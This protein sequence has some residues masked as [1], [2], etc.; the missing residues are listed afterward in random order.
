MTK[1]T[2]CADYEEASVK[3]PVSLTPRQ[4]QILA[5]MQQGKVNKEIARELDISLGT[6]KQHLVAIFKKLNVQ[7]RTMAVAR[8]AEFKDQSGFSEVFARE[9]LMAM[10]PAIVLSLQVNGRLPRAAYKVFHQTLS[11]LAFDA[12]ALFISRQPGEGD[13]I[14]GL[15]RSS[16]QDIR[17]AVQVAGRVYQTM[18]QLAEQEYHLEQTENILTGALVAGLITVSQDRFGGWS[19][20]TIGSHI[21]SWGHDLRKSTAEGELFFDEPV[22]AVMRAFDLTMSGGVPKQI[23]F[24]QTSALCDWNV[25]DDLPLVGRSHEMQAIHSLLQNQFRTLLL[26]GENGMGKSRLC[27]EAAREAVQ[28]GRVLYY[29]RVL[30]TGVL[31]SQSGRM[32]HNWSEL[33]DPA[34]EPA[35]SL[36]VVEDVHYLSAQDQVRF[37]AFADQLP[38]TVR[39]LISG[40]QP[41]KLTFSAEHQSFCRQLKLQRLEAPDIERLVSGSL[42][43]TDLS[44]E[45]N[46]VRIA[47]RSRG[48][49]LF[50]KELLLQE[51]NR[52]SLAL[53]ITVA[54]RIDKFRVDWKLLYCIAS[55][56]GAV[57]LQRLAQL[58]HDEPAYIDAAVARAE[59]L[60][61]L[62][63]HEAQ[64]RFRHP[65]VQEV[66]YYLFK[67]NNPVD[68]VSDLP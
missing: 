33:F 64:V 47:E 3:S 26:E 17:I 61:V 8:L 1:R 49:P 25:H 15:R 28:Q 65:L 62:E 35:A 50:A 23:H 20:E 39:L 10:R 24:T 27:R 7:N 48:V 44:A 38:D 32:L 36:L 31:D 2:L 67:T 16:V 41:L 66:V 55:H 18:R 22:K 34:S 21:L 53:L 30:P 56:S 4:Q 11:D 46:P 63:Q 37:A 45:H 51:E 5:L 12:N 43:K 60:G 40:R 58:M 54:A 19:G 68:T 57:S 13:L 6:V 42:G 9:T 14:L 29:T 52:I 59:T